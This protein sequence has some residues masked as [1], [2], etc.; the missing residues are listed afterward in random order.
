MADKSMDDQQYQ[1]RYQ[2]SLPRGHWIGSANEHAER[3]GQT[4]ITRNHDAIRQWAE[5]RQARPATVPGTEHDDRP[6]VLRF[7]FPGYGGGRLQEISWDDWFATFDARDLVFMYQENLR[8]GNQSNFFRLNSPM[9][10]AA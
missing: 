5:E 2:S 10:E 1:K 4:L 9:R 8:N 6:G 3:D 7:Q